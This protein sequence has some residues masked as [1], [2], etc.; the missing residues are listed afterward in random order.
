MGNRTMYSFYV[1]TLSPMAYALACALVYCVSEPQIY[2]EALKLYRSFL[3][4]CRR[5]FQ[6]KVR[7]GIKQET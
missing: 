5:S 3:A 2:K 4:K 1:V 7:R 6:Q